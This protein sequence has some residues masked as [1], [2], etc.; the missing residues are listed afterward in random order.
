[1]SVGFDAASFVDARMFVNKMPW[2][3]HAKRNRKKSEPQSLIAP[4]AAS[5]K[6][7]PRRRMPTGTSMGF[8]PWGDRR[9]FGPEVFFQDD[10]LVGDYEGLDS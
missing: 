1:M 9:G 10:S 7:A 3:P 6:L 5:V 2:M 4:W 8:H